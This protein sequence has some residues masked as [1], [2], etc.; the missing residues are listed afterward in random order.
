M[1]FGALMFFTD[2]AIS[3]V[4][5]ARASRSAGSSRSGHPSIRT[6]RH[7]ANRPGLAAVSCRRLIMMRWTRSLV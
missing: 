1:D 6:F 4:E 7:R 5:L 3:A 2:Y